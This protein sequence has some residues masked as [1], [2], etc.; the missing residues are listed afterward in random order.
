MAHPAQF[1][2]CSY[3]KEM[4]P[5]F[6]K[7]T[8]VLE[9]GSLNINGTVR[10]LFESCA[11]TGIDIGPGPCVDVVTKAH[12]YKAAD[13]CYDT[14]CSC[15]MFEHDMYLNLSLPN[16]I[17]L[18]RPNGLFFFTCATTGRKEHGTRR[19][20]DV[21]SSPLTCQDAEWSD[22]Y[23]NLTERD[24]RDIVDIEDKFSKHEFIDSKTIY[25][26]TTD[27]YFWGIKK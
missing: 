25:P 11:Y 21:L 19:S 13:G 8:K 23:K 14:V 5:D 7:K 16:L 9:A 27:L 1:K 22:Y 24:I 2:F 12:E 15:E 17:R 18:L 6:F 10:L 4:F 3:V 26:G 20:G